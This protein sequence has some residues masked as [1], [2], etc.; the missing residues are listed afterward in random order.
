MG[1]YDKNGGKGKGSY[2]NYDNRRPYGGGGGGGGGNYQTRSGPYPVNRERIGTNYPGEN[3]SQGQ[4]FRAVV[5]SRLTLTR[6]VQIGGKGAAPIRRPSGGL[7]REQG[8]PVKR[9]EPASLGIQSNGLLEYLPDAIQTGKAKAARQAAK[10]DADDDEK[11]LEEEE[12]EEW[13][14]KKEEEKAKEEEAKRNAEKEKKKEEEEK[15]QIVE[16]S[17]EELFHKMLLEGCDLSTMTTEG[18]TAPVAKA[19]VLTVC[20]LVEGAPKSKSD[21]KDSGWEE[22]TDAETGAHFY[23]HR[24]LCKTQWDKPTADQVKE[25]AKTVSKLPIE[26]HRQQIVDA[27]KKHRV[28]II[29]GETGS[30]KTT[31]APQYFLDD[32]EICPSGQTVIVTQPRRIAAITNS[33]RVCQERGLHEVGRE[34]GYQIRFANRTTEET[35][36][37]YCTTAVVLRQM[38]GDPAMLKCSVLVVDE[39]HERDIHTEFLLTTIKQNIANNKMPHLRLVLMTATF[40][41]DSFVPFFRAMLSPQQPIMKISGR[42]YPV[43][44]WFLEDALAWT[45]NYMG[46]MRKRRSMGTKIIDETRQRLADA[47]PDGREYDNDVLMSLCLNNDKNVDEFKQILI[48]NIISLIDSAAKEAGDESRG[49]VL[50]FLPGWRDIMNIGVKLRSS[51]ATETGDSG[52]RKYNIVPLH[53]QLSPEEQHLCFDPPPPDRRKIILSTDISE[54]SVTIDDVVYVINAG[55]TKDKIFD[56]NLNT[57]IL[58]SQLNTQTSATQRKGRAGRTSEGVC[59]HL[60]SKYMV[61]TLREFPDPAI[62]STS[63]EEVVLQQMCLDL[64]QPHDFLSQTISVPPIERIDNAVDTLIQLNAISMASGVPVLTSL[65]DWLGSIPQ[66]P[67]TSVMMTYAAIFGVLQPATILSAFLGAKWP[68]SIIDRPRAGCGKVGLGKK[69]QSD[70]V[71]VVT[72]F[73]DYKKILAGTF[74]P[75]EKHLAQIR[76]DEYLEMHTLS[77]EQMSM[78]DQH[79]KSFLTFM[80]QHGYTCPDISYKTL[81]LGNWPPDVSL[82]ETRLILFKAALCGGYQPNFSL[83]KSGRYLLD[84]EEEVVV[85]NNSCNK[86]YRTLHD[87]TEFVMWTDMMAFGKVS[88]ND[89][90]IVSAAYVV[91]FSRNLELLPD[92]DVGWFRFDQWEAFVEQEILDEIMELRRVLKRMLDAAVKEQIFSEPRSADLDPIVAFLKK[93]LKLESVK[94]IREKKKSEKEN[95]TVYVNNFGDASSYELQQFLVGQYGFVVNEI[96]IPT[97]YQSGLGKG[98]AFVE[99]QDRQQAEE[100]VETIHDSYFGK[101]KLVAELKVP[102]EAPPTEALNETECDY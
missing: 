92:Y 2:S 77:K 13:R 48:C 26:A 84:N 75:E 42:C 60:F 4:Q 16:L 57:G 29:S 24:G 1:G 3:G 99:M 22:H 90:T 80:A 20:D 47:N 32:P 23:H 37:I 62:L 12:L 81:C 69:A 55:I 87:V 89:T 102:N 98:F 36:L 21:T 31:Q 5:S 34:V 39:V 10:P 40:A 41:E 97:D 19:N 18:S 91:L 51:E 71:A 38:H 83:I 96:T 25:A 82:D 43:K 9:K 49:A 86:A 65:G 28:V 67:C 79:V 33:E 93:P 64:G 100:C 66:H 8:I 14:G 45:G 52:M 58:E 17:E 27:V 94:G 30:G 61:S 70:H 85:S 63:L 78:A 44:E 74:D 101:N 73:L 54:T 6:P 88:M 59:I 53:G 68:F 76:A 50:V 15:K 35:R 56:V 72:A 46:D 11:A 95:R 7:T